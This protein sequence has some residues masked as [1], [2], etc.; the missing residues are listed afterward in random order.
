LIQDQSQTT[1]EMILFTN[2]S[3]KELSAEE[4]ISSYLLRWPNLYQ[5][6]NVFSL[7]HFNQMKT[8][9]ELFTSEIESKAD[10][11]QGQYLSKLK[12]LG[13][14]RQGKDN[15][16]YCNP[17][18]YDILEIA[19]NFGGLLN[20]Y[21]QKAFFPPSCAQRD[22]YS[23]TSKFYSLP[24]RIKTSEK[25]IKI[26]LSLPENYANRAELNFAVSRINESAITDFSQRQLI[27]G[28][29]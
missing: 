28:L 2:T 5:G 25:F 15:T 13:A 26:I 18:S 9:P 8:N 27:V 17:T 24:G 19:K 22:F 3:P 6:F 14:D 21:C 16:T 29:S 23:M 10:P 20:Q 11:I 12:E 1:Q 4:A 7:K